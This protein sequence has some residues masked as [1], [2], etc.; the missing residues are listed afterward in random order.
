M[1]LDGKILAAARERLAKQREQLAAEYEEKRA[2]VYN[3]APQI[4]QIDEELNGL[5]SSALRSSLRDGADMG[6]I[7][8]A[9]GKNAAILRSE[10]AAAL[11]AAGFPEDY[12]DEKP[13]CEKCGDTGYIGSKPCSCLMDIYRDE[14]RLSLSSLLKLG[15]ESFD[16]FDLS[17]YD[18]E[19]DPK[20]GKTI[21]AHMEGVYESCREYAR[22]F[23][24]VRYNLFMNGSTGLG[25]TFLSAC[26]AKTVS[27][28]GFSVVY[29]SAP[30]LFAHFEAEK[31]RRDDEEADGETRRYMTC[32]LL[33][34]DD[35]GTELTTA[36]TNSALYGLINT[37]LITGKKTIITSNYDMSE[38]RARYTPQILSR[39]EGE[40]IV[41]FFAGDDIRLKRRGR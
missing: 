9:A 29:E 23:K 6:D 37:R 17:Y 40:Y 26:I 35:L 11:R 18:D 14:Q 41:L 39:L 2:R 36:F 30:T 32:D 12:L 31:F 20:L 16:T 33:I 25:K 7:M 4:A 27:Q 34:V 13:F 19:Y 3:R 1:S 15:N 10:R 38:L 5:F 8:D 28:D 22:K 24:S 21:R